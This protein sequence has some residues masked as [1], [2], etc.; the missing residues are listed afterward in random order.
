MLMF[1]TV[2][3][4]AIWPV[5]LGVHVVRAGGKAP[6]PPPVGRGSRMRYAQG[7]HAKCE[8]ILVLKKYIQNIK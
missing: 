3:I 5:V 6:V 1:K 2:H 4:K 8:K 7:A